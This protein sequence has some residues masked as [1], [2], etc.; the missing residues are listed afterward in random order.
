MI[1][2][3]YWGNDFT[4]RPMELFFLKE[5]NLACLFR[6]VKVKIHPCLKELEDYAQFPSF[7]RNCQTAFIGFAAVKLQLY[8]PFI[9]HIKTLPVACNE[10]I[11]LCSGSGA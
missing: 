7:L 6:K 2:S 9:E 10:M 8:H 1:Y 5:Q 3:P 11:D 4:K